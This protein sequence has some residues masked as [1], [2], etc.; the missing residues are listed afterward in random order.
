VIDFGKFAEGVLQ[1][2]VADALVLAGV[3][4][5]AYLGL[6]RRALASGLLLYGLPTAALIVLSMYVGYQLPHPAPPPTPSVTPETVDRLVRQWADSF[7]LTQT[8]LPETADH[9]GGV[10]LTFGATGVEV[11]R[12]KA[13]PAVLLFRA[14]LQLNGAEREQFDRLPPARQERLRELLDLEMARYQVDHVLSSD[15]TLRIVRSLQITPAMT[16]LSLADGATSV[17]SALEG[18]RATFSL[19]L[20]LPAKAP[21]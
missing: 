6:K 9:F 18:A 11:A 3:A 8:I 4:L 2:W 15:L 12:A 1:N 13:H 21:H 17:L 20:P 19:E 7:R 5:M 16:E 10:T 14:G